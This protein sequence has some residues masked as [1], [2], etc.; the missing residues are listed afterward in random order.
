[1]RLCSFTG[2]NSYRRSDELRAPRLIELRGV[3]AEIV[4]ARIAELQSVG[5]RKYVDARPIDA[6]DLRLGGFSVATMVVSEMPCNTP[7][8][9]RIHE[10]RAATSGR[11][12]KNREARPRPTMTTFPCE[13]YS[14]T[15]SWTARSSS[16]SK[17]SVGAIPRARASRARGPTN[18]ARRAIGR[19]LRRL[20]R[21]RA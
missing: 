11:A 10:R 1:M 4:V 16:S 2:A 6:I 14:R 20:R 21:L 9:R 15:A 18:S 19:Y 17:D 12:P 7:F 3:D 13:A 8:A 5:S